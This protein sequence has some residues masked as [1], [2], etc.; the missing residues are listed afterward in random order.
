[1]SSWKAEVCLKKKHRAQIFRYF[2]YEGRKKKKNEEKL[3]A[4]FTTECCPA[5][6]HKLSS[7]FFHRE[8]KWLNAWKKYKYKFVTQLLRKFQPCYHFKNMKRDN[9]YCT[10]LKWSLNN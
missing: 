10:K 3:F 6:L 9:S 4:D 5:V 2:R 7:T 1:M 8:S